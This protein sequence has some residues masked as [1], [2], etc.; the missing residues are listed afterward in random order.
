MPKNF[1]QLTAATTI[2]PTDL[3]PIWQGGTAKK[4]DASLLRVY[5]RTAAE[6]A[7]SLTPTDY[8]VPHHEAV[9]HFD[10]ARYGITGTASVVSSNIQAI[11]N[12]VNAAGGGTIRCRKPT[13]S[14]NL[15]T[16]GITVPTLVKMRGDNEDAALFA[17]SG[18][19]VGIDCSGPSNALEN[20]YLIVSSASGSGIRFGNVSR[21]V[22]VTHVTAQCNYS[23]AS[24]RTGAGLIFRTLTSDSAF[25]GDFTMNQFYSLGFKYGIQFDCFE[26][27]EKTWTTV[28]GYNVFLVGAGAGVIAGSIGIWL[29]STTNGIGSAIYGGTI[30]GF[31]V[32]IQ[33]DNGN[34]YGINYY[35]DIEG[36]TTDNPSLPASYSGEIV[37]PN[38]GKFYRAGANLST[39]RWMRER[40]LNGVWERESYYDQSWLIYDNGG[41]P[42]TFDYYRG[43]SKIDGGSPQRKFRMATGTNSST[44]TPNTNYLELS[45]AGNVRISGGA[46][47]PESAVTAGVGSIYFRTDGGAGTSFYV[48]ESGTGNTGWIAK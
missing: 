12:M 13:T 37:V 48:K 9:G 28:L 8:A 6:I 2:A 41:G 7:A 15:G 27:G 25:S 30:E 18:T 38:A 17:Y 14:Y 29:D 16:T 1:S 3:V 35:G 36:N 19:G 43:D 34:G 23:P 10:L 40:H 32:P 46:G 42:N 44:N 33:I 45:Y 21:R 22:T 4:L 11:I 5:D 20:I 31:E 39:N 26:I 47:S 24:G